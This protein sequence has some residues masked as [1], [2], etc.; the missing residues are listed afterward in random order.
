MTLLTDR[1]RVLSADIVNSLD[2]YMKRG[3]GEGLR[4]ARELSTAAVIEVLVES[5]L[6][7]RGGGGFPTGRKWQSVREFASPTIPTT[8]VVNG[9]EG[10]PGSFKDRMILRRNPYA[11]LEGALIA[12]HAL[13]AT[14]V[15]VGVKEVFTAERERLEGAAAEFRSA[16]WC[17]GID[18]TV[19]AGPSEYLYGEETALL[20][21]FDGRPPFPRLAP[22]WRRGVEEI[23]V[24]DD[25]SKSAADVELATADGVTHAPPTLVDNVETI[26]N[27]P[28]ILARGA[29]WF[30]E[31]GTDD[32]PGTIVV[33]IT[34][35]VQHAGVAEVPMGTTL[36]S[37]IDDIGGGARPGRRIV[38][39]MSGVSNQVLTAEDLD[40]EL[41]YEAMNAIGSGLGAAGFIVFDD[42][43]DMVA[44]A[45][46]AARFL[47]VESCGQCTPCK[48]DGLAIATILDRLRVSESSANDIDELAGRLE[49]VTDGARCFLATQIQRV[50]GSITERFPEALAAHVD[51]TAGVAPE[52][53]IAAIRELDDGLV[54]LDEAELR[55]QPDWS[56]DRTDSG[57]SPADRLTSASERRGE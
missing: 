53:S 11:V 15:V 17:D 16:G 12:A 20:E 44:V 3:G 24:D 43:T 21:V 42:A 31:L 37:V 38:G 4:A 48:Q 46:G 40:T 8:V 35:A 36:S 54:V 5:G 30:R 9:A 45:H 57:Q 2:D 39:A 23:R 34:G 27:V 26:A 19:F 29:A 51:R 22:P 10:E 52:Y 32:S 7:G 1:A 47:A 50:V 14:D 49:T 33:T 56:H 6:R 55:K 28:A 18:V 41:T 25:D 13:G